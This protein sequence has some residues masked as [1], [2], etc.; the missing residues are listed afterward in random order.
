MPYNQDRES[1]S[2]QKQKPN[3]VEKEKKFYRNKNCE[4]YK[5]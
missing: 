4:Y 3:A 2:I 1:S 5:I